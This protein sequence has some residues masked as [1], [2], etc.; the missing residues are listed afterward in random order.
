V[1]GTGTGLI[2]LAERVELA[3]GRLESGPGDGEFV[4]RV[5]L[6]W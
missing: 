5:W 2:G 6:P 1:P 4:L 3:G